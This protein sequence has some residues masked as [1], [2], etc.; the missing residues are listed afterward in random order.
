[1]VLVGILSVT[2]VFVLIANGAIGYLPPLEELQNPKNKFASEIISSDGE[3]I[4]TFFTAKDNRIFTTYNEISPNVINA[5]IATEDARFY[6]H[7][8]IDGQALLRVLV[9]RGILQQSGAGGGSTITQQLAK[10]L[11]SPTASNI[12]ERALQKPIEWVIATKLEKLYT[13][14]EIITMYLNKFDFLNNAVGIETAARVYFGVEPSELNIEQAATLVGMCKNPSLFNPA[15]ERRRPKCQERRNVVLGQMLKADLI[16]KEECDSLKQL[17]IKLDY[18]RVDHKLGIAP[19][20]REYLRKTLQAKEPKRKNYAS[21]QLKPYGQYYLDSLEWENNP[22]YGWIEKN[23]K[24]DGTKYDIYHDGLKIYT[25]IDSRMQRYA[26]KAVNEHFVD[27]QAKF[28]KTLK[29]KK[30]PPFANNTSQ[31]DVDR[32]LNQ[33]MRQCDRYRNLKKQKLTDDEIKEIFNTPVEMNIFSYQGQIDTVMTPMDSIR[34]HKAFARCGM[35]SIDPITGHV[36]AYVGGPDFTY[37]QYD[38]VNQGR[39]QV[40]ST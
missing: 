25:T 35:M 34:Y 11:Y 3:R 33:A 6:S 14:E 22:L 39:R 32:S 13:K 20:F 28:M 16:T 27:M 17:P 18:H 37:F 19:Y 26:E 36:K 2:L 40:G 9:K 23:P 5:L 31:E 1:M 30:N 7:S 12:F 4:G 24:S 8:G 10:Q 38:M 15:S 21:W 29:H